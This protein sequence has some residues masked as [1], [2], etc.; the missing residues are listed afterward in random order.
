MNQKKFKTIKSNQKK[1]NCNVWFY[2]FIFLKYPGCLTP[3]QT[4]FVALL[5]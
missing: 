2:L 5:Y 3:N 4:V 1:S